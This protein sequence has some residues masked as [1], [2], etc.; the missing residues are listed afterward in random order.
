M[1]PVSM[2]E[3]FKKLESEIQRLIAKLEKKKDSS[4]TED[5]MLQDLA[6][7]FRLLVKIVYETEVLARQ[8]LGDLIDLRW[9]LYRDA[10]NA[11]T[12]MLPQ[13]KEQAEP[14]FERVSRMILNIY[15]ILVYA[16]ETLEFRFW[17]TDSCCQSQV[18]SEEDEERHKVAQYGDLKELGNKCC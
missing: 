9:T 4:E 10:G 2:N 7:D 17:E 11:P 18:D 8:L 1:K 5:V 6:P 16:R 12:T 14:F 15:N 3:E 13:D